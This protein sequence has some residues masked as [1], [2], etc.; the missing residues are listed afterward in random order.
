LSGLPGAGADF[1]AGTVIE[2]P[3]P[4]PAPE[5]PKRPAPAPHPCDNI[6]N[7]FLSLLNICLITETGDQKHKKIFS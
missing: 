4:A 2:N 5:G 3:A 1:G 6:I 7:I